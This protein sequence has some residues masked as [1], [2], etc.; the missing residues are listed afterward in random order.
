MKL[1][2]Q[3]NAEKNKKWSDCLYC[4]Y[5]NHLFTIYF[6]VD[7][8]SLKHSLLLLIIFVTPALLLVTIFYIRS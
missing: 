5:K 8:T 3:K 2:A 6:L 1:F 4:K 7:L